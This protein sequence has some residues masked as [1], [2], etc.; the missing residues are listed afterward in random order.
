[1]NNSTMVYYF[2]ET[3]RIEVYKGLKIT[4]FGSLSYCC[5]ELGLRGYS[6]TVSL[7]RAINKELRARATP[8][9]SKP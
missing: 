3:R 2:S 9:P 7:K 1:M 6:S 8:K 5:D 4:L